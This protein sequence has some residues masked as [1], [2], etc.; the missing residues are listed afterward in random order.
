MTQP[1]M[2]RPTWAEISRDALR[3][4]YRVLRSQAARV[5]ADVIAVVKANAYGHGA[6]EALAT[7]SAEG[8]G[9]FAATCLDEACPI[10][11]SPLGG[12]MLLL[13]GVYGGEADEIVRRG[14]TP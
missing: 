6:D 7:L 8:C 9:W 12:R 4:N 1:C 10:Q 5:D 11:L 13:S 14:F 2:T 3:T